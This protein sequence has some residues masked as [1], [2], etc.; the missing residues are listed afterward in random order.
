[1]GWM[2]YIDGWDGMDAVDGWDGVNM[3]DGRVDGQMGW[4]AQ[5]LQGRAK[6]WALSGSS[7]WEGSGH[8]E[9]FFRAHSC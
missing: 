8:Q 6:S 4:G 1:M 5:V 7:I 2:R 9:Q 3:M